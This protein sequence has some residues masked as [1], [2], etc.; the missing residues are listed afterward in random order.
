MFAFKSQIVGDIIHILQGMWPKTINSKEKQ[1]G[2]G[3][4]LFKD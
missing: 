2:P 3:I 4:F 1:A